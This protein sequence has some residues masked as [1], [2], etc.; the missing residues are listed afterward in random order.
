MKPLRLLLLSA[1]FYA[2]LLAVFGPNI[3]NQPQTA[4]TTLHVTPIRY[5]PIT[6]PVTVLRTE[7]AQPTTSVELPR[8]TAPSTSIVPLVGPDTPC[9]EWIPLAVEQGWPADR[10]TLE[11]LASVMFRESRCQP[12]VVNPSSPDHGLLQVNAVHR[13]YVEQV[14]GLPF[15]QAMADPAMNLNFAWR[16]YSE[17]EAA[18][19]CGWQPWS[20]KCL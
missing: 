20:L 6:A 11:T 12:A 7:P 13:E 3:H 5:S 15:E 1:L 19:K 16:L 17:L 8:T 18:G 2:I 9:Q 4:P 10:Q 14:Y